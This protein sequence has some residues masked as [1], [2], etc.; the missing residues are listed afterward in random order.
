MPQTRS[1]NSRVGIDIRSCRVGA[2]AKG[3]VEVR[4][5]THGHKTLLS[6]VPKNIRNIHVASTSTTTPADGDLPGEYINRRDDKLKD[7]QI[8]SLLRERFL[9]NGI[10]MRYVVGLRQVSTQPSRDTNLAAVDAMEQ[11]A[12]DNARTTPSDVDA[13]LPVAHQQST[14]EE[15]QLNDSE[16]FPK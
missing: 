15:S 12:P 4:R 16:M 14:A 7:K 13:E 8:P 2:V 1:D 3:D 10:R 11:D 6:I 5:T 9:R